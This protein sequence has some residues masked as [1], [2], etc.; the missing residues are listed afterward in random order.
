MYFMIYRDNKYITPGAGDG[1]IPR[2]P[3]F[4]EF[5]GSAQRHSGK[6]RVQIQ[7][8]LGSEPMF[9]SGITL[10]LAI[11]KVHADTVQESRLRFIRFRFI[12]YPCEEPCKLD[13]DHEVPG[14]TTGPQGK[15]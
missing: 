14:S 13:L 6:T 9:I 15:E 4:R 2:D 10:P 11:S 5:E 1:V 3:G 12:G 7:C 8:S